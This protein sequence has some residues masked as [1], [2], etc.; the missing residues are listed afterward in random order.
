V[1]VSKYSWNHFV[2]GKYK[3]AQSLK[4]HFLQNNPLV[5]L[6]TFASDCTVVGKFPGI[7]FV[8]AFSPLP[9]NYIR[10]I[11]KASQMR[12]PFNANFNKN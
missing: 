2:S 1:V 10:S 4:L 7:H 11:T 6:H 5:L 3:T 9:S 12:R 8:K